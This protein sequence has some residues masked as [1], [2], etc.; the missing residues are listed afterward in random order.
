MKRAFSFVCLSAALAASCSSS[1][2]PT[3]NNITSSGGSVTTA[4]GTAVAVPAGALSQATAITIGSE[5]NAITIAD[6]DLVGPAYR[7]G[8]EGTQFA[9]PATVTLA[10][11]PGRLPTGDTAS[12]VVIMT[13]PVGSS[14]FVDLPTAI[15]DATHV[16]APT[17][18]FSVFVAAA[19]KKAHAD[20]GVPVDAAMSPV[21]LAM[22][23]S[24]QGTRTD[25][26]SLCPHTY[27]AMQCT[28]TANATTCGGNFSLNCQQNICFCGGANG[29]TCQKPASNTGTLCPAQSQ[30][31]MV[32]TT[33]CNFP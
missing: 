19:H 23:P 28:L 8:P 17:S 11:D 18:H 25:G 26:N 30:L 33:C 27:N 9:Q 2:S 14:A 4:D 10:Y 29:K 12:D 20:Q 24:D 21:D 31:E 7:F 6:A 16:S 15:V 32:W 13:A 5:P 3:S 1:S 22:A